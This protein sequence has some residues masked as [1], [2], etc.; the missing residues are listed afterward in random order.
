[1]VE[2]CSYLFHVDIDK[3]FDFDYTQEDGS[4]WRKKEAS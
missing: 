4:E 2:T 1:M 3:A